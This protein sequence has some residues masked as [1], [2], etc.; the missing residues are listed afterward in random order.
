MLSSLSYFYMANFALQYNQNTI[1]LP[2]WVMSAFYFWL[3]IKES[4]LKNWVLLAIVSVLSI[5]AK[6][7][8]IILFFYI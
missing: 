3:A 8:S 7:E 4:N 6:Y 5:L 1:M 2:F